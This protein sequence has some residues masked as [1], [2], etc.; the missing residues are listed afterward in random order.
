MIDQH[1]DNLRI[2]SRSGAGRVGLIAAAALLVS[3]GVVAW[4][5][6]HR[7]TSCARVHK[8]HCNVAVDLRLREKSQVLRGMAFFVFD[9]N[10][11]SG[12]F[13]GANIPLIFS[14]SKHEMTGS[15]YL[16]VPLGEHDS[17][18]TKQTAYL[19]ADTCRL[20][21]GQWK[22]CTEVSTWPG[23]QVVSPV[24]T[25]TTQNAISD[26]DIAMPWTS[27]DATK[28]TP[29]NTYVYAKLSEPMNW[30]VDVLRGSG[31]AIENLKYKLIRSGFGK[32]AKIR[33]IWDGRDG[34]G[35]KVPDRL[36]YHNW[37]YHNVETSDNQFGNAYFFRIT[38]F[39]N[40]SIVQQTAPLQESSTYGPP[41]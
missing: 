40:N 2:T 1:T 9:A 23:E 25:F 34:S 13:Y 11:E 37:L 36:E 30:R 35:R 26:F 24:V 31:K 22:V 4:V 41:L 32:G 6:I 21:N 5:G 29:K 7:S 14:D 17:I 15:Y 39:N 12:S 38:A 10:P 33:W 3:L 18:W 20:S 8:P 19:P 28:S 27:G 16:S